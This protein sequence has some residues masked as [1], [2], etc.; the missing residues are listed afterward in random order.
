M[1]YIELCFKNKISGE[2]KNS[3]W[4]IPE[5]RWWRI[6]EN[7]CGGSE[8]YLKWVKVGRTREKRGIINKA[9]A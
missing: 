6:L 3:L 8:N 7:F 1:N 5:E 2:F 9:K 4:R